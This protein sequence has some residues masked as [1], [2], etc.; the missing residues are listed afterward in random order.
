MSRG[1]ERWSG[2][3]KDREK[4][5][6]EFAVGILNKFQNIKKIIY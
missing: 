1:D 2:V 3:V 4:K 6:E 5:R